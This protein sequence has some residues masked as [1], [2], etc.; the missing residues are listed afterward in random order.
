MFIP[1]HF[2]KI[3]VCA[4]DGG[5]KEYTIEPR[6]LGTDYLS[7]GSESWKRANEIYNQK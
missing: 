7:K 5:L 6:K 2:I 3:F 1:L 4:W